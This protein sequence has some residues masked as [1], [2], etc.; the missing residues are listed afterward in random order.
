ML[1]GKIY[2]PELVGSNVKIKEKKKRERET[3]TLE[4]T[5]VI[6]ARLMRPERGDLEGGDGVLFCLKQAMAQGKNT[7]PRACVSSS[8]NVV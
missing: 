1:K 3:V 6:R 8:Q 7:Q 5:L 2:V 4:R